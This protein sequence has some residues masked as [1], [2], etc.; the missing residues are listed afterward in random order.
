MRVS[1]QI[2]M[3]FALALGLCRLGVAQSNT[4]K[5]VGHGQLSGNLAD[6]LA[7]IA[8]ISHTP[9]LAELA[10]PLPKIQIHE[11]SHS[12]QALL[13]ETIR[14]A[15][16]YQWEVDGEVIHFY[17]RK[18]AQAQFN[19]LKLKF[20][21]YL[22]PPNLS[23]LK[24]TFPTLEIGLL[25]GSSERGYAISGFGD[26]TFEKEP[27]QQVTLENVSA[28][29]ILLRAAN[30]RP[31]FFTVIVFPNSQPTKVQAERVGTNWFWQSFKEPL[32]PLYTQ[33]AHADRL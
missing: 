22:M 3:L 12:V 26:K 20:P 6:A 30:E 13:Q 5:M 29:E 14:Q 24:L 23:E 19:F 31:S 11:G 16:G 32:Q 25:R 10:Q 4:S 27:L 28:R 7:Q 15:P 18:L 33:T 2:V 21:H 1:P 17:H 8:W 9:M